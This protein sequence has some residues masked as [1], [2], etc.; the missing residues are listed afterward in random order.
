MALFWSQN[1]SG[2]AV[3]TREPSGMKM[4]A[5][6]GPGK[7]IMMKVTMPGRLGSQLTNR[8]GGFAGCAGQPV[9]MR[10]AMLGRL[11]EPADQ[12]G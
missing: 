9:V 3:R 4:A 1:I 10:A 2:Y 7:P 5:L 12:K 6:V 11:G 8:R